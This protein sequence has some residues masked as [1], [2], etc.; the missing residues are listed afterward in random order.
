MSQRPRGKQFTGRFGKPRPAEVLFERMARSADKFRPSAAVDDDLALWAPADLEPVT[1]AVQAPPP[2]PIV[3]EPVTWPDAI[4]IERTV[5]AFG[6]PDRRAAAALARHKQDRPDG[7]VL[8]RYHHR[9]RE[10]GGKGGGLD[11]P[12][13]G[14]RPEHWPRPDAWKCSGW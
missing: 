6:E 8:D 3:A 2:T 5:P 10:E 7:Q 11:S 4:E 14:T 12:R 1:T 13:P 9:A